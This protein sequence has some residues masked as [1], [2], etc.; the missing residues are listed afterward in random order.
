MTNDQ[1]KQGP[2]S[3]EFHYI[4]SPVQTLEIKDGTG[5]AIDSATAPASAHPENHLIVIPA[6]AGIQ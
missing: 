3:F 4:E 5:D 6:Q 1:G 2:P